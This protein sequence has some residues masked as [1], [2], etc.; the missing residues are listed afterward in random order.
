MTLVPLP[1]QFTVSVVSAD[2]SGGTVSVGGV[3]VSGSVLTLELAT[4]LAR[5]QTVTLDYAFLDRTPLRAADG[6][7]DPAPWF[8]GQA[9]D[10]SL[11]NSP[12]PP[13]T[14]VNLEVIADP[15]QL[16]LLATWDE[17]DGATSYK[18]RWRESG[19]EFETDDA[20]IASDATWN[21]TVSDYGPWEVRVQACNDAGCG[22]EAAITVEAV[23]AASLRLKRAVDDQG[24]ARP[25]TLTANWDDVEG[26]ASYLLRW[27]PA[28]EDPPESAQP[29]SD[30][31]QTRSING[32]DANT[33]TSNQLTVPA[34]RTSV[35]FTVPDDRA[36][37]VD[38]KV[39]GSGNK[40][41]A[42]GDAAVDQALGQPDTMPT[43]AAAGR[44]RRRHHDLLLQRA[45][46]RGRSRRALQG[47]YVFSG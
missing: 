8:N 4:E 1:E 40:I 6:W 14:V 2:G 12:E 10:M 38:L 20:A 19:G 29:A 24:Q 41:L 39:R 16:D 47:V 21:V 27:W 28:N 15:G 42:L 46:G 35:D 33:K 34:G 3:S 37:R 43:A 18:L 7:G 44:D 11:L 30:A 31:R 22:P 32:R 45:V 26:A 9:V 23:R 25:R 36:Y 13:G 17:V 5:G